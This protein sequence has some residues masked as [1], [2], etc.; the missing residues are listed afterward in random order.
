MKYGTLGAGMMGR[1]AGRDFSSPSEGGLE[2]KEMVL[3]VKN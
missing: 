3:S 1:Q 2:N